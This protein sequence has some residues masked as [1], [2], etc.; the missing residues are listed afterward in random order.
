MS[1]RTVVTMVQ[2]AQSRVR[3]HQIRRR[4]TDSA[5]RCLFAQPE[6]DSVVMI[7]REV[8]GQEPPEMALVQRD[9]MI[10][11]IAA[12]TAKPALGDTVLPGALDGGL[13]ASHS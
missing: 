9:D 10:E 3:N 12:A 7:I 13:E 11:Q 2:I 6:M 4:T 1:S 8:L 5:A